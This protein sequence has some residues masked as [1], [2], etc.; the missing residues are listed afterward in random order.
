[1]HRL[2]DFHDLKAMFRYLSCFHYKPVTAWPGR[3]SMATKRRSYCRSA[4][5]RRSWGFALRSVAPA[6]GVRG[7][8]RPDIPTCRLANKPPRSLLLVFHRGTGRRGFDGTSDWRPSSAPSRSGPCTA[9]SGFSRHGQSVPVDPGSQGPRLPWA[10]TLAGFRKQSADCRTHRTLASSGAADGS[11]PMHARTAHR[12]PAP[13]AVQLPVA[14]RCT[15]PS[16]R[17]WPSSASRK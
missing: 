13:E 15:E 8:L 9:A 5:R 11:S 16:L 4:F 17:S 7:V 12:P 6:H 14:S 1:M 2:S 10:S 3:S